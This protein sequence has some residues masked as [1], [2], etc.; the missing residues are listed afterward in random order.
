MGGY[1]RMKSHPLLAATCA[2]LVLLCG[3]FMR[4]APSSNLVDLLWAV[5]DGTEETLIALDGPIVYPMDMAKADHLLAFFLSYLPQRLSNSLRGKGIAAAVLAAK[6]FRGPQSEGPNM[7]DGS[8]VIRLT[9]P[10]PNLDGIMLSEK[11]EA[12][13]LDNFWSLDGGWADDRWTF[14]ISQIDPVTL[15]VSTEQNLH[16]RVLTRNRSTMKL[17]ELEIWGEF[18][19]GARACGVRFFRKEASRHDQGSPLH[20]FSYFRDPNAIRVS[21]RSIVGA[22]ELEM[23]Y[24]SSTL[25]IP[26]NAQS[27]HSWALRR[28]LRLFCCHSQNIDNKKCFSRR[29]IT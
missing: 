29:N 17:Q 6:N 12:R 26:D 20:L 10:L 8:Y 7:F 3:C 24:L 27:G 15:V 5:T 16:E 2:C 13:K 14:F 28:R 9:S 19:L 22:E 18:S 23:K 4:K 25:S 11:P 21:F 1:A